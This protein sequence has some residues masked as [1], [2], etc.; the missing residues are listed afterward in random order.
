MSLGGGGACQKIQKNREK[1]ISNGY[2]C[3]KNVAYFHTQKIALRPP[4]Y[5]LCVYSRRLQLSEWRHLSLR[6]SSNFDPQMMT[7]KQF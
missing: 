7:Q 3:S 6:G 2:V 4:K 1:G 5:T